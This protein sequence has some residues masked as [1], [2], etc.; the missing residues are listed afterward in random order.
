MKVYV[1]IEY[2]GLGCIGSLVIFKDAED[3]QAWQQE[4]YACLGEARWRA[5]VTCHEVV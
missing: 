4:L 3:A 2:D 1:C 5:E